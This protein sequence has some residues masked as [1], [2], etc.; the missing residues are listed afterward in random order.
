MHEVARDVIKPDTL[1]LGHQ[2]HQRILWSILSFGG[3][4]GIDRGGI[5]HGNESFE[6]RRLA[7]GRA[8]AEPCESREYG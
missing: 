1:T 6:G 4:G 5:G 8:L 2:R 3:V 7:D